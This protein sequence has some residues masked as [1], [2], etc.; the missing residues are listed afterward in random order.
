MKVSLKRLESDRNETMEGLK[1]VHAS[2]ELIRTQ[3][4]RL[5]TEIKANSELLA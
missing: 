3:M 1:Q 5:A 4:G 2:N